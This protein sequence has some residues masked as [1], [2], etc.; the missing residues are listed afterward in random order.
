MRVRQ[1][2]YSNAKAVGSQTTPRMAMW[3]TQWSEDY[4]LPKSWDYNVTWMYNTLFVTL[5]SSL[6]PTFGGSKPPVNCCGGW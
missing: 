1:T 4:W 3:M 5:E 2:D 6:W